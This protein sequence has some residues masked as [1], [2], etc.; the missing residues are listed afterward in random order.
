MIL[1]GQS[2]GRSRRL[3]LTE[4]PECSTD[5][6]AVSIPGQERTWGQVAPSL[7]VKSRLGGR[8]ACAEE[9]AQHV[10]EEVTFGH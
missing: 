5:A 1:R 3:R 4:S 9:L 7:E 6:E 10:K 2:A 8:G